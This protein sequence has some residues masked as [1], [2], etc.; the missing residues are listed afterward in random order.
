MTMSSDNRRYDELVREITNTLSVDHE[1]L[2]EDVKQLNI[3][4]F[5]YANNMQMAVQHRGVADV[6][7]QLIESC[8]SLIYDWGR[9]DQKT[10]DKPPMRDDILDETEFTMICDYFSKSYVSDLVQH[11]K[12]RYGVFRGRFMLMG[13]KTCL[14]MHVDNTP[15]LHIPL[16]TNPDCFMVVDDIVCRLEAQKVYLVDTR[17]K[18][19][20]INASAKDRLHLVFCVGNE[21]WD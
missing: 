7:T 15:R 17:L 11:L 8:L 1:R 6:K 3:L 10:Q 20:A 13:Y 18:H 16:I 19:T 9:F 2:M 5:L 21:V 4:D 12:D 14:S